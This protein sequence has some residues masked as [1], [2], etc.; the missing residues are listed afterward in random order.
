MSVI[1]ISCIKLN[2]EFMFC[3][4]GC[5]DVIAYINNIAVQYYGT[6]IGVGR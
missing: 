2:Q 4:G 5:L 3:I 6:R 1:Y